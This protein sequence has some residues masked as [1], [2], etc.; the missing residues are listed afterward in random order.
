MRA[1]VVVCL[2]D[3]SSVILRCRI[4]IIHRSG[5]LGCSCQQ[6]KLE[7]LIY[8]L[9]LWH[10]QYENPSKNRQSVLQAPA[11]EKIP[12]LEFSMWTFPSK[13]KICKQITE[14]LKIWAPKFLQKKMDG[15]D[16]WNNICNLKTFLTFRMDEACSHCFSLFILLSSSPPFLHPPLQHCITYSW[17]LTQRL[18]SPDTNIECFLS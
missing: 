11:I 16:G 3:C 1:W 15:Q 5:S 17:L 9:R 2:C 13:L 14:S 6:N 12:F 10:K 18:T 4:Y 8:F 7:C